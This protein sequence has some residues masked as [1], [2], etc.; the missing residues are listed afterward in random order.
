MGDILPIEVLATGTPDG[1]QFVRDDGVL[2]IPGAGNALKI[3]YTNE[4]LTVATNT[5]MV[6]AM[7]ITFLGTGGLVVSG[8]GRLA[9]L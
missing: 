8:T 6:A 3:I 4:T 7:N 5:Q 2:A 9:V 1:T